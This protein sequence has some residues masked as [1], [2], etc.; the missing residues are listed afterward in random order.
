MLITLFSTM[1]MQRSPGNLEQPKLA[2]GLP[3]TSG[4]NY[5]NA[6]IKIELVRLTRR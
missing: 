3:L 6:A 4:Q 5:Y 2:M 1:L